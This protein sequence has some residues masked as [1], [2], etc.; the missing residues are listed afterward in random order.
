MLT[1]PILLV[2]MLFAQDTPATMPNDPG[3]VATSSPRLGVATGVQVLQ[4]DAW[5]ECPA[6]SHYHSTLIGDGKCHADI[7]DSPLGDRKVL[8]NPRHK[9]L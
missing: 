3:A 1:F 8:P 5:G 7:D 2:L 4:D 6:F 9:W